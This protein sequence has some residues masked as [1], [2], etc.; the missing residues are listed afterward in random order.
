MNAPPG[1]DADAA[2]QA[3]MA[4][5]KAGDAAAGLRAVAAARGRYPGEARLWHM[6]GFLQRALHD[7][8]AALISCAKAAALSPLD[9]GIAHLHASVT[10]EAGLPAVALYERA[11]RIE[12][13]DGALLGLVR[14]VQ[15][16]AGPAAAVPLLDDLLRGDPGWIPG[17]AHL[18]RL[19]CIA[20]ERDR[21]VASFERALAERPRD[22]FMW[23]E[24]ITTLIHAERFEDALDAVGRAREAAGPHAAF[25]ADEAVCIDELGDH[26]AAERLFA[27][28][29]G[30]DDI[31]LLVRR[32]RNLLRLGRPGDAAALAEPRLG[33]DE[34]GL[35]VPYLSVAWRTTGDPRAHWLEGDERLVGVY[36]L[37]DRLPELDRLADRLRALH[38]SAEQPLEQSVRG[39]TQSEGNLLLRVAPEIRALRAALVEA[40][41]RH[42]AQLPPHDAGHPTLK[43][44]RGGPA[45]LA[46]SWS[47]R[48]AGDGFHANHVHP[49]GWFSSAFYLALPPAALEHQ[50]WLK[51]GE[52]HAGI[53]SELPPARLIEPKP[54]R[55]VLFPSTMWHGT[56]PFSA[57][58]RLTVSA[59]FAAP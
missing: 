2:C 50:G 1:L 6:S 24:L 46:G 35:L 52:P 48:L 41:A 25:D 17:H 7:H 22:I 12:R 42:L 58:E 37:A 3:G 4:A 10:L 33:D 13:R 29:A 39:G 14:A 26:E 8:E 32:V 45:R 49:E 11:L 15:A 27:P 59:D 18:A 5:F 34:A 43:R 20:G 44:R 30:N 53:G 40:M 21:F 9:F 36:D 51:L 56:I 38:S 47:V 31:R 19:R 16:E 23:C 57:G 55:F 54:G 28:L